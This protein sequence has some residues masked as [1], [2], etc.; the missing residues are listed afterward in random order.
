VVVKNERLLKKRRAKRNHMEVR[1]EEKNVK[2]F[3]IIR[4]QVA[5]HPVRIQIDLGSDLDCISERFV[6]RYNLSTIK[7]PDPVRVR[8]FNEEIVGVVSRQTKVPVTLE[9]VR[10]GRLRLDLVTTDVD[11]ILG[12]KWL[13]R[14]R[15]QFGWENNS[16]KWRKKEI[17]FEEKQ[18]LTV[19]IVESITKKFARTARK[20][21]MIFMISVKS[22]IEEEEVVVKNIVKLL[23]EYKD[24]FSAKSLSDLL[25]KRDDD[26]HAIPTVPRVRLQ[27]K[28]PYRLTPEERKVLKT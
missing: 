15:P 27:A 22:I 14:N 1:W 4:G 12:V 5:G 10:A 18:L 13:R 11:V 20:E 17:P 28:S 23:E 9:K 25:L 6:K 8:G 24:V 16:L 2:N 21:N 19:R 3:F 26:D 7:H